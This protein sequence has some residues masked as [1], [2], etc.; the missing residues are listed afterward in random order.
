MKG[1][2]V[3]LIA[4]SCLL[5]CTGSQDK[6]ESEGE[7]FDKMVILEEDPSSFNNSDRRVDIR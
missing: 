2:S 5:G 3:A 4:F 6:E 7:T 1:V